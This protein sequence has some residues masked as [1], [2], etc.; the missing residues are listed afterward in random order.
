[1]SHGR[2]APSSPLVLVSVVSS[3]STVPEH[4]SL[5][6]MN[7]G[8]SSSYFFRL[9]GSRDYYL[10]DFFSSKLMYANEKS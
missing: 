2:N 10:K 1:M 7:F 4:V 8:G 9:H 5:L 6:S 3:L